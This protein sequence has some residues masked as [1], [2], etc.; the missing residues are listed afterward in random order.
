MGFHLEKD[1]NS[2][3]GLQRILRE[4]ATHLIADL[5]NKNREKAIHEARKG[6]KRV[7]AVVRLLR[8][9]VAPLYRRENRAFR[10]L[11]RALSEM[12]DADAQIEAFREL[13]K[14]EKNGPAHYATLGRLLQETNRRF[15]VTVQ[16]QKLAAMAAQAR[17]AQERLDHL[18]LP[19]GRGLELIE[20]G[21]CQSYRRGREAMTIA[22]DRSQG[23]AFH[24]WRKRVKDLGYQI[25]LLRGLWPR[26]LKGL[27]DELEELGDLLGQEHDLRM[28][29]KALAKNARETISPHLLRSFSGLLERRAFE[30]QSDAHAIGRR[31]Y[32]ESPRAF[33]KRMNVYWRIWQAEIPAFGDHDKPALLSQHP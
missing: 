19:E 15:P 1:E 8:F 20:K 26:M 9:T 6:C 24:E 31:L 23:T 5:R 25:H 7:R 4:Q 30:L 27:Q 14:L 13:V 22:F 16:K 17:A 12:R 3:V 32:A 28:L 21:L 29:R 33:M 2:A 18:Q 10:C 11:A